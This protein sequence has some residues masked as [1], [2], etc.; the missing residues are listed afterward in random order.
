MSGPKIS[1]YELEQQRRQR[2]REALEIRKAA[3]C[4]A[5]SIRQNL[6]KQIQI[7]EN[8]FNSKLEMLKSVKTDNQQLASAYC[9]QTEEIERVLSDFDDMMNKPIPRM[10]DITESEYTQCAQAD[11]INGGTKVLKT[12]FDNLLAEYNEKEK[13]ISEEIK[14]QIEYMKANTELEMQRTKSRRAIQQFADQ[15]QK[16]INSHESVSEVENAVSEIKSVRASLLDDAGELLHLSV[17]SQTEDVRNLMIKTMRESEALINMADKVIQGSLG[18]IK[19]FAASKKEV[20]SILDDFDA[21]QKRAAV[22]NALTEVN[23]VHLAEY[24]EP[25]YYKT[26]EENA[27]KELNFLLDRIEDAV[28]NDS[29]CTEDD[30]RLGEIYLNIQKTAEHAQKSLAVEI[31]QAQDILA[32]VNLRAEH[33][34]QCYC[35]YATACE[36]LNQLYEANG[37]E[38]K[39]IKVLE[40]MDYV[41]FDALR[42]EEERINGILTMENEQCFIRKTINEV[43]REFG[44]GMAEEFV[45]HR[46]QKGTHLLCRKENSDTAIHVHYGRGAKKRIMLEVVGVRKMS[47]GNLD[48]G[49]NG[50]MIEPDALTEKRRQELLE[51]QTAF[52]LIHPEIIKA[53]EAKG[54]KTSS[55]EWNPPGIEFCEEIAI[56]DKTVGKEHIR[57]AGT[58][59]DGGRKK[60]IP[61]FM[62]KRMSSRKFA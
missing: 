3:Y 53:L 20:S 43:M 16:I 19:S 12:R 48:N 50:R 45:L 8:I 10:D 6:L 42:D 17:P 51:R 4:R 5:I 21:Q 2:L 60:Q 35:R 47:G 58:D 13:Q 33:F 61:K 37:E 9:R 31:I 49:V 46:Q 18:Q 15:L 7:N 57:Q 22:S 39:K 27:R 55:I 25:D 34:E 44:Y 24:K 23:D 56:I 41:S 54:I 29:V 26:L 11:L 30:Q 59:K 52:C 14:K 28:C 32:Q 62:E 38:D 40:R 1:E 36:M